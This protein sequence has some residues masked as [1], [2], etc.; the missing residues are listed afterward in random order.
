MCR[1]FLAVVLLFSGTFAI[2]AECKSRIMPLMESS[3]ADPEPVFEVCA[4]EAANDD[5]EALYYVSFFY[6]GLGRFPPR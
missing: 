1:V 2:G 4:A 6:F 3:E 5:A